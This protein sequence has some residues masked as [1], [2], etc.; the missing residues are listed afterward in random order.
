MEVFVPM[1]EALKNSGIIESIH[2]LNKNDKEENIVEKK[3]RDRFE[4]AKNIESNT[5]DKQSSLK[6]LKETALAKEEIRV[7][8]LQQTKDLLFGTFIENPKFLEQIE[9]GTVPEY[10]NRDNTAKRLLKI[11]FDHFREGDDRNAFTDRAK[12][13]LSQAY[14]DVQ[15]LNKGQLPELVNDTRVYVFELLEEFRNGKSIDDIY[16]SIGKNNTEEI[17]EVQK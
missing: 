11:Y 3:P 1:I 12:K 16:N 5:Y 15:S 17:E 8:L 6:Q 2:K 14:G 9:E 13:L 10:F 4:K 7:N